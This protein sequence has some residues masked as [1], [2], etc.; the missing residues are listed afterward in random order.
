MIY[1]HQLARVL[2]VGQGS[3]IRAHP[4]GTDL[5]PIPIRVALYRPGERTPYTFADV[6]DFTPHLFREATANQ[7]EQAAE[8]VLAAIVPGTTPAPE[9]TPPEKDRG[10][11]DGSTGL[12][13]TVAG[14]T[15]PP[16]PGTT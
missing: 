6:V 8:F 16:P 7:P 10:E 5:V 9:P 2:A 12:T 14:Y 4:Q 11:F 15:N 3:G 1:L 13:R